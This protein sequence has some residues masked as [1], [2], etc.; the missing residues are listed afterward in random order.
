MCVW[1]AGPDE[2]L[3]R[4]M[5]HFE[6]VCH[7]PSD[8]YRGHGGKYKSQ[9]EWRVDS[10][11]MGCVWTTL[12][13]TI[14]PLTTSTAAAA[15]GG[16]MDSE[17]AGRQSVAGDNQTDASGPRLTTTMSSLREKTRSQKL[18]GSFARGGAAKDRLM[19]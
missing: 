10:R 13:P 17:E 7:A 4:D 15:A 11:L 3:P 12:G 5:A 16:V 19:R 14:E 1:L 6:F 18:V 8:Y 2:D 9:S